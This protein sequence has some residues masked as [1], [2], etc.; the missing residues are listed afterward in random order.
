MKKLLES[1]KKYLDEG[2]ELDIEV[3]DVLL[4][5]KYK[6]KRIIVKTIGK[7]ENGQTTINGK[8]LLN[9]RIEKQLPDSKK[10]KKTLETESKII[11]GPWEAP[12]DE[13]TIKFVNL[14]EYR[15]QKRLVQQ[16]GE[17]SRVPAEQLEQLDIVMNDIDILFKLKK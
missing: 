4:G 13:S 8:P 14:L 9:F 16:Y 12:P 5:G 10:S 15:I 2:I 1:W 17:M 7:D 6:N 3:G 11:Q